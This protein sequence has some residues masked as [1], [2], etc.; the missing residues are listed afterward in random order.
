MG[1]QPKML[2]PDPESMNPDPKHW[3]GGHL[4]YDLKHQK[5]LRV[6]VDFLNVELW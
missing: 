5:S 3:E 4:L 1:I 6:V 2:D